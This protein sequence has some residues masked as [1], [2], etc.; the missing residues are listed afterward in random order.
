MSL[1]MN[2]E[3]IASDNIELMYEMEKLLKKIQLI[4][5]CKN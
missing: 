1:R 2:Y 3:E 4:T 5:S